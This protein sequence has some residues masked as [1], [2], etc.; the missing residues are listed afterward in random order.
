M[1]LSAVPHALGT[2]LAAHLHGGIIVGPGA[3][4]DLS[5]FEHLRGIPLP[6]QQGGW[7]RS[8]GVYDPT[9][10]AIGVGSVPSPSVSV[11]GHELGHATDDMDHM[12]SQGPFW[13]S[14]H[15]MSAERLAPLYRETVTELFAEAFAC[16]LIRRARRLIQ[17]FGDEHAAQ[18][19][20][21]W[22]AGRYGIG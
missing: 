3:V 21:T 13:T 8:A 1:T 12:P 20:Y 14:L 18:Q 7:E 16:V 22:F 6:V 9:R 15:A 19:A 4:P 11:A 5:G 2:R 17:L 10:R